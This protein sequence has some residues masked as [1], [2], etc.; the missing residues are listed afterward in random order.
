MKSR[1]ISFSMKILS[2][3]SLK[4]LAIVA[5]TIDHVAMVFVNEG[6][7]LWIAMR[8]IGR[9]TAPV[10]S[11]FI[12]EGFY[13][14]RDRRKYIKRMVVFAA[15]SQISFVVMVFG[16]LP[17][18]ALEFLTNLNVMYTF[19]VSLLLL[20]IIERK[21]KWYIQSFL[22]TV[23]GILALFGDWG[24]YIPI[25]V[26]IFYKF[27]KNFKLQAFTFNVYTFVLVSLTDS[28]LQYAVLFAVIPLYLYNG[29]RG[30]TLFINKWVF[31]VYYP[32]HIT[33]LVILK[34]ILL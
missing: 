2:A 17:G 8:V 21:F 31:Y 22:L 16:R 33:V 11:F 30:N 13:Y 15:I 34:I 24:F 1:I 6:S 3:D 29:K 9:I 10:M 28:F 27:R 18:S 23:C 32:I 20:V 5:M 12:A 4:L 7:W 25:W 26:V 19:T 14:T